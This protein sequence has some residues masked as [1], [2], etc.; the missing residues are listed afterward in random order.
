MAAQ[1]IDGGTVV[2]GEHQ[3]PVKVRIN[4]RARRLIMRLD[5]ERVVRVT[6]PSRRHLND[7]MAMVSDRRSWLMAR[8][9]EAPPFTPLTPGQ[10]IPVL[11]KDVTIRLTEGAP[12]SAARLMGSEI[13]TG[14]Q[15]HAAQT[16][17]VTRLLKKR[18]QEECRLRSEQMATQLDVTIGKVSVRQMTSRWGSCAING[19]ICYN[20]RLIF[21]PVNVLNY[22]VAHEVAHRKFMD[23]SRKFWN[24]VEMLDPSYRLAIDYL[25]ERGA[26]LH[27]YGDPKG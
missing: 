25:K 3:L 11:G 15:D 17:R 20:W 9:A 23:H 16:R 1:M 13:I 6:C 5:R 8:L 22:V 27:A 19:D 26:E 12:N 10:T 2:V 7:A 21:A 24:V 4:P 14:G 18:V